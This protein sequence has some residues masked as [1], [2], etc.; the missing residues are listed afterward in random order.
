MP[1]VALMIDG[2]LLSF[3]GERS[4]SS[5][6]SKIMPPRHDAMNKIGGFFPVR[7]FCSICCLILS[8]N[9]SADSFNVVGTDFWNKSAGQ[10]HV[11]IRAFPTLVGSMRSCVSQST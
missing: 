8:R 9:D 4:I 1:R 6:F 3:P 7:L 2:R 5:A 11:K 10:L